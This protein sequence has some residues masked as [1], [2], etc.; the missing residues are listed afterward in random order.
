[1]TNYSFSLIPFPDPH[2]PNITINGSIAR[3]KNLLAISYFL[4]GKTEEIL[5]PEPVRHSARKDDL[6]LATCFEYFL[7]IPDQPQYWEFNLSPSGDWNIYQMDAYRRVGFRR[8]ERVQDL[9]FGFRKDTD[10]ISLDAI[11]DLSPVF[12][13]ATSIQAAITSVIQTRDG[14][15]TYWALAH[16]NSTADF[17]LRESFIIRI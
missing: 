7:A 5:F 1:M 8:E 16:P 6:W 11:L 14:Y 13:P 9:Q 10:C 17:H 4:S 15:E 3:E 2:L 12:G